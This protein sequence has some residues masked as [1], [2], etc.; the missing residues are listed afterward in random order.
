[1]ISGPDSPRRQTVGK[2]LSFL[3]WIWSGTWGIFPC[4]ILSRYYWSWWKWEI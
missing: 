2:G 1:M 3:W 4:L